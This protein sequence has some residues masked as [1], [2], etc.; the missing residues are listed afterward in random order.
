MRPH[1]VRRGEVVVLV[2]VVVEGQPQV[3]GLG[4]TARRNLWEFSEHNLDL[5]VG[6]PSLRTATPRSRNT[7]GAAPALSEW[8]VE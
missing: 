2:N 4:A 7:G 6:Q 8:A 3:P 5:I 1:P